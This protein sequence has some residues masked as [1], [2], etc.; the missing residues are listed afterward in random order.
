MRIIR[1]LTD[2]ERLRSDVRLAS[3]YITYIA[4]FFHELRKALG[5]G[6][7]GQEFTLQEHGYIVFLEPRGDVR[8]LKGLGLDAARAGL[9]GTSPEFVEIIELDTVT[10]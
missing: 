7:E 6:D 5:D 4:T 10:I 8:R 3:D 2:V 1:T 9:L